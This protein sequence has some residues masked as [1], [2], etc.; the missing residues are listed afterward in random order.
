[1]LTP[2][3][4]LSAPY[5]IHVVVMSEDEPQTP[6]SVQRALR[7][8]LRRANDWGLASVAL[9]PLGLSVGMIEPEESARALVEVLFNHLDEGAAPLN[10]T[11][12]VASDFEAGLFEGLVQEMTRAR[13]ATRN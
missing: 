4:L 12:V 8:G 2:A 11:I 3:G 13:S 5:L 1:V 7:N 10:L 6:I 9:P